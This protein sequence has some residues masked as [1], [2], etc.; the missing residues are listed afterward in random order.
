MERKFLKQQNIWGDVVERIS[1]DNQKMFEQWC[2]Y[3][4]FAVNPVCCHKG[5]IFFKQCLLENFRHQKVETKELI[6]K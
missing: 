3:L 4:S 2:I 5:N 1:Q 6:K